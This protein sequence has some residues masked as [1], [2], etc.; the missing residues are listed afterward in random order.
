M[1]NSVNI[2]ALSY[3]LFLRRYI[4][5]IVV[6][7]LVVGY[8]FLA[9]ERNTIWENGF[10][11][12]SNAISKSPHKGRPHTNLGIYYYHKEKYQKAI[13]EFKK[14]ISLKSDQIEAYVNLAS[15]YGSIG[16][17]EDAIVQLKKAL[18]LSPN[19]SD[20]HYNLGVA[21]RQQRPT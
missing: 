6:A 8:G 3:M 7:C 12:W 4:E 17:T 13:A 21:Y 14:G 10:S 11:L 19:N 15:V 5:F 16:L 1:S 2:L 20:V 9:H 18:E